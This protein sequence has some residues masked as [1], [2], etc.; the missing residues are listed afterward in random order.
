MIVTLAASACASTAQAGAGTATSTAFASPSAI[1]PP[2]VGLL[3]AIAG[4]GGAIVLVPNGVCRPLEVGK[5]RVE[6]HD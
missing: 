3:S 1:H 2:L 4:V 6:V 5:G